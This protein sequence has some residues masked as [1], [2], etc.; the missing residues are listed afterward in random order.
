MVGAGDGEFYL[1]LGWRMARLVE[2]GSSPLH[3]PD[4][5]YP[6]G[7]D[8]A[9]GDGVG[10][11]LLLAAVN[12][13]A[14][15][16]YV[17]LNLTVAGAF[18]AN[19]LAGRR[20]ARVSGAT[21]RVVWVVTALALAASPAIVN[22][23]SAHFHFCFVFISALV[24][25]EAVLVA[26]GQHV[27]PVRVGVLLGVAF[28]LSFYWFM[29]SVVAFLAI[30]AVAAVRDSSVRAAG[31]R[32]AVA[33]GLALVLVLPL[34]I[35]RLELA[36][37]EREAGGVVNLQTLE[38]EQSVVDFSA[39]LLAVWTPPESTRLD[40]PGARAVARSFTGNELESVIFP[41]FLSLA[42]LIA[43]AF[44]RSP[45]RAPILAAT[46]TIWVLSLGPA[47]HVAGRV[48]RGGD[49]D[50]LRFLPA[51]LFLAVP[52]LD[53]LRTPS[54]IALSLSALCCVALAVV[55]QR[56]VDR[57]HGQLGRLA[58]GALAVVLLAACAVSVVWS[59]RKLEPSFQAALARIDRTAAPSE[60]VAEVPFD[61]IGTVR[62]ARF[63]L[64]HRRPMVGFYGQYAAIPWFSGIE[65]LKQSRPLAQ[66]RCEPERLGFARVPFA[67]G[68][69]PDGD[70]VESLA[71]VGVRYLLVD[72]LRL[73]APVCDRRRRS[74]E[75]I[76]AR[77]TVLARTSDWRVLRLDASVAGRAVGGTE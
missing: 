39:D 59:P 18:F 71:E 16:P 14:R 56:V 31:G 8:V 54:R 76:L 67:P 55:G 25:A 36:S 41:G 44:V 47:L 45:L 40:F 15:N 74:I 29:T 72:E 17:A 68:L 46:I 42:A 9:L 66:L 6:E 34:A 70:E 58:V 10:A 26:R 19:C 52:G 32:V 37:R 12:L 63:Q 57:V 50:A 7:Y 65:H 28:Y 1:W 61:A 11:Y 23:A 33:L 62:T 73:A 30:V 38:N 22:R 4:A 48:A 77:A 24:V 69:R 75:A 3:I 27:R 51:Q 13:V 35:P 43:F 49:G 5:V 21:N 2:A 60:A 53:V 20:L 64:L